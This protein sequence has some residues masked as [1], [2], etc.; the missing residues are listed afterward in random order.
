[1]NRT[2]WLA[3]L[4]TVLWPGV[5]AFAQQQDPR[6]SGWPTRHSQ[7]SATRPA[8]PAPTPRQNR[9]GGDES[10]NNRFSSE[11]RQQ[12]RRDIREHGRE[13]YRDRPRQK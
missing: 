4:L 2:I 6:T 13:V 8:E 5:C 12:L 9:T 10:R 7:P 3:G 1:M 11:E